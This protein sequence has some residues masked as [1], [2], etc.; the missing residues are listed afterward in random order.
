EIREKLA[1]G[2]A[3]K[4]AQNRAE[5]FLKTIEDLKDDVLILTYEGEM[6]EESLQKLDF[7]YDIIG[8]IEGKKSTR[9]DTKKAAKKFLKENV[10]LIVFIGGDGTAGDIYEAVEDKVPILA[11]PSGVKMHSACFAINPEVAGSIFRQFHSGELNLKHSEVM[12]IDEEAFRAGRVSAELKGMVL[13]PYLKAALQGGKMAS[14]ST[15]DER[16]DQRIIGRRVNEDMELDTL[17]LLGPGTT[18]KAV[19]DD[20]GLG[21]TLLGIDAIYN[22]KLIAKDVNE[23]DILKLL[24]KYDKAKIIVTVIGN[25]GFVFG[26]GNQQFSPEVIREVGVKN[27]ILIATV[28]KLERT[29]KLR[30]DTGDPELDDELRGFVRVITSYHED[31]MM[32][33][34]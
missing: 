31:I 14:P 19:A 8:E 15:H 7:N 30:V 10:D 27:I 25:Q 5:R 4:V 12:D 6:G 16:Q 24:E 29:E 33:I 17:Y 32:R 13:I 2:E 34:G 1:S 20:L 22:R 26:R 23:E 11:I 3:E 28:S 18:C 9:K 21:K